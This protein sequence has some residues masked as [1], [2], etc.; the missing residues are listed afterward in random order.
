M[1]Y[2]HSIYYL[3]NCLQ[4]PMSERRKRLIEAAFCKMDRLGN[5]KITVE[6]LKG[7]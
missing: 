2:M 4:P 6:D 3:Y 1:R 7:E 5:G